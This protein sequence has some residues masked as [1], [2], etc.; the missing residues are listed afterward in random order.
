MVI[1]NYNY[2]EAEQYDYNKKDL[3]DREEDKELYK[4]KKFNILNKILKTN[5][6][7]LG[8][9]IL[10]KVLKSLGLRDKY[11]EL[12]Y[13]AAFIWAKEAMRKLWNHKFQLV[14]KSLMPEY[15]GC[16]VVGNHVS[17]IDPFFIAGSVHRPVLWMSKEDNFKTPI[18]RTLFKNMGAFKLKR[19]IK[20][21]K[22]WDKA[23]SILRNGKVLGIFPE[24]TRTEDG[25]IGEFKTG[26][27]RL[28]IECGVPIVPCAVQGS[29]NALPKG[30]LIMKPAKVNVRVGNAIYYTDYI[31]GKIDYDDAKTL[32]N[33]LRDIV[34]DLFEGRNP[35]EKPEEKKPELSIGSPKD[36]G[37]KKGSG[38]FMGKLKSLGKDL[39]KLV[40]DSWY[41]F[42]KSLEIFDVRYHLQEAIQHFSANM[43]QGLSD[44]MLPTKYID[45][46][47]YIPKEGGALVCCNHNSEW[48]VIILAT[49]LA[50][51]GRILYQMAKD[52]LFK[53][54]IVN[55]W[56]RTHH[57]FP[58]KRGESDLGSYMYARDR[59]EDGQLVV[60]YP[61]GTTNAGQGELLPGHTGAMRL[62][63]EAKVPIIPIGITGTENIFPKHAKMLNFGK[64]CILKA[65]EHFTE[66]EK[67]FD[68]PTPPTYEELKELTASM[69][70][71]IK[72]LMLYD[73]PG[74]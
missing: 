67:F 40:D 5:A 51:N 71:R 17:H 61:E 39:L 55:A 60:V 9:D 69:M 15:G 36:I 28:A 10:V 45:Y 37:K 56:I 70:A 63:I 68:S 26:A 59:L 24:G 22:A 33:E 1:T 13:W 19:G 29:K 52:S 41:A 42:I 12:Q 47:E 49:S 7:D 4:Q 57:A 23:K 58:L 64:G 11:Y 72:D 31:D 66:H 6:F 74:V 48:D 53:A 54:P 35:Y 32:S 43:V 14:G 16:I 30:K 44:L 46:K 18:V 27:V 3:P 2:N 34:V 38:G 65:G 25:S 73:T 20:D 8:N 21:Q 50:R 62:A